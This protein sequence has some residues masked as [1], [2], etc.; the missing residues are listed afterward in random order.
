[1]TGAVVLYSC[2]TLADS[3]VVEEPAGPQT[4]HWDRHLG[5]ETI[6][7]RPGVTAESPGFGSRYYHGNTLLFASMVVFLGPRVRAPDFDAIVLM[8]WGEDAC[9]PQP[10]IL[11]ARGRD[12]ETLRMRAK[13]TDRKTLADFCRMW[14]VT[15][16]AEGVT[17][18]EQPL[19][20]PFMK[21]AHEGTEIWRF[22]AEGKLL[23]LR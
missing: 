7:R 14:E 3:L 10:I 16:G 6:T 8:L 2:V 4:Y 18:R 11:V 17:F 13:P 20:L 1:M 9:P 15:T 5:S 21:V 19:S 12:V 23:Q 22:G